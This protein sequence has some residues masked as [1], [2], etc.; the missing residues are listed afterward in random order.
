MNYWKTYYDSLS[1][2]ESPLKQVG[3]TVNGAEISANQI[4]LI[5]DSIARTLRLASEDFLVDL[6]CGNGLLTRE[7]A[8]L[9]RRTVGVDYTRGLIDT[10]KARHA[11]HNVEY[12]ESDI[13][14][15]DKSHLS[16]LKK[17]LM[18]EALQHFAIEQLS[19]L[20]EKF[21]HL[22]AGS[23]VLIGSIPDRD[24]LRVFY[25]TD[26]K[27]A[28]YKQS[29]RERKP[30]MGRWWSVPEIETL[31]S[32]SGALEAQFLAQAPGLYTAHYRFDVLLTKCN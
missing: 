28:F 31:V 18:Y 23:L 21:S 29:E 15:L 3:K 1:K 8:P 22:E 25:D 4:E 7:L 10:A 6:C 19:T 30:H 13:M 27:F 5:V 24:K 17:V 9:V 32:A 26:E 16:G 11:F 20:L 2:K 14:G 12:L